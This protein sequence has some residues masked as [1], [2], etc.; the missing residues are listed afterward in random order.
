MEKTTFSIFFGHFTL[1]LN[2]G[3]LSCKDKYLCIYGKKFSKLVHLHH[4]QMQ[5][6]NRIVVLFLDSLK[7]LQG[8]YQH[9]NY[10]YYKEIP[11]FHQV[12]IPAHIILLLAKPYFQIPALLTK[13]VFRLFLI[14]PLEP[15][16]SVKQLNAIC[17]YFY[18]IDFHL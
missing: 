1:K 17:Q 13:N 18:P 6:S 7:H 3:F 11:S 9:I 12:Q 15:Y 8:K 16:V 4:F 5:N 14:Q 2:F 10:N